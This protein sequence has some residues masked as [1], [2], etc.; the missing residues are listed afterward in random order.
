[1]MIR[2]L[3]LPNFRTMSWFNDITPNFK[4]SLQATKRAQH[5]RR[6][7]D[8]YLFANP[9]DAIDPADWI[10][11]VKISQELKPTAYAANKWHNLSIAIPCIEPV[12]IQPGEIF[13]FS[14]LVGNP[15]ELRG[16]QVGRTL[17]NGELQ[18][19]AGG[20]L[21][22]LAGLIYLLALHTDCEI[23]ERH[24]H[25]QDIYTDATRFT[26]LGSDAAVVFGYKDLRIKNH[27]TTP[28]R[29]QFDLYKTQITGTIMAMNPIAIYDIEFAIDAQADQ[30]VVQTLRHHPDSPKPMLLTT[31]YYPINASAALP[32]AAAT[33]V[34]D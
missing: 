28:I 25:S 10:A 32:Q 17:I 6:S 18:A 27:T 5:D 16:Y 30:K 24:P 15:I 21:C 22:Q 14:H 1:M 7:G 34:S 26:P 3:S 2:A 19:V 31:S 9:S 20:G 11:Q 13:S 33:T 4:A 12:V 23:L 29:F 8:F